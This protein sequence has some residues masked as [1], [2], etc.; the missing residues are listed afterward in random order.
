ME[1]LPEFNEENYLDTLLKSVDEN[2][3]NADNRDKIEENEQKPVE[4]EQEVV[5][6]SKE[7][8]EEM[9]IKQQVKEADEKVQSQR[10]ANEIPVELANAE[11]ELI[12]DSE[13]SV[14]H[15]ESSQTGEL[16]QTEESSQTRESVQM[17][18]P[19][20][21]THNT[22]EEK[23]EHMPEQTSDQLKEQMPEKVSDV[24]KTQNSEESVSDQTN[25][26]EAATLEPSDQ[27]SMPDDN[28]KEDV[29]QGLS[30]EE[31]DRLGNM[32]LDD[33][34][35]DVHS[36][37]MSVED[38]FQNHTADTLSGDLNRE[39]DKVGVEMGTSTGDMIGDA[40][41][42]AA[43]SL[44][45]GGVGEVLDAA[46]K[47]LSAGKAVA[48]AV[49]SAAGI[50]GAVAEL[51]SEDAVTDKKSKK[52]QSGKSKKNKSAK[53]KKKNVFGVIKN[54]FFES[55]EDE[56]AEDTDDAPLE[57]KEAKKA[58]K[59]A[60]KQDKNTTTGNSSKAVSN[61]SEFSDEPE[62]LDENEM[63]LQ[64]MYGNNEDSIDLEEIHAPKKGF[65]AKL[66]YRLKEFKK[67]QKEQ[68]KEEQEAES[69]EFEEKQ[70]KKEEKKAA[71]TLKKEAQKEKAKAKKEK[72][73]KEKK[74]KKPKKEKKPKE[75]PKPGDILK[76]KPVSMIFFVLFI[77]GVV[78]LFIILNTG[79]HYNNSVESARRYI[80]NGNYEKAYEELS[81]VDL[82]DK[83]KPLYEKASVVMYVQGQ[84]NSYQ[85]NLKNNDKPQALDSLIK[86]LNRYSTYYNEASK[87]GVREELDHSK[88]ELLNALKTTFNLSEAEASELTIMYKEDFTQYYI[89]IQSYGE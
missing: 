46:G 31:L 38:M 83:D 80:Q 56:T 13:E 77:A 72:K 76:I 32:N 30:K 34:I 79:L 20:S 73:P 43:D 4:T 61:N 11:D 7:E 26:S 12:S 66:S 87:L 9:M 57:A 25:L 2:K 23:V 14:Q 82:K 51:A 65:F 64:E 3:A 67:K 74:P 18:K 71:S 44:V 68:D 81:G 58:G 85:N 78:V 37:S 10:L 29:S 28:K 54:I 40:I 55:L 49:T 41:H 15:V 48:D 27:S 69:I 45:A 63:L 6:S 75:P 24:I 35:D 52:K 1:F 36:D 70:K 19:E 8:L 17:D 88:T 62:E 86:G 21:E 50:A 39:S 59:N 84:Y 42:S 16:P 47:D 22:K 5:S 89:K 53:K 33:I 60:A